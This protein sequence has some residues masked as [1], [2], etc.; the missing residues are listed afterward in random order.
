M[1]DNRDYILIEV[2]EDNHLLAQKYLMSLGYIWNTGSII[3]KNLHFKNSK[4]CMCL[5]NDNHRD[6]IV[7][8][9]IHSVVF[10]E[11]RENYK[12]KRNFNYFVFDESLDLESAVIAQKLGLL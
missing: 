2:S 6:K 12:L 1:V 7:K 8:K 10:Y 5:Y 3:R 4:T 9:M 11:D